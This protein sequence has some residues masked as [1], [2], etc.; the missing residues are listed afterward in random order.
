[1]NRDNH[2][3]ITDPENERVEVYSDDEMTEVYSEREINTLHNGYP[4]M[5]FGAI[6]VHMTALARQTTEDFLMS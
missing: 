3:L 5:K 4:V 2:I 6:H 1:M